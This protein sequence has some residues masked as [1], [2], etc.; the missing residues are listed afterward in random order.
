M[1][2]FLDTDNLKFSTKCSIFRK[3]LFHV[4]HETI[5]KNLIYLRA[6]TRKLRATDRTSEKLADGRFLSLR[7][8]LLTPEFLWIPPDGE[9]GAVWLRVTWPQREVMTSL[10]WRLRFVPSRRKHVRFLW[11]P[12]PECVAHRIVKMTSILQQKSEISSNFHNKCT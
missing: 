1:S 3:Q 4:V 7:V 6:F 9:D 11:R 8:S 2:G 12:H 5:F 10:F